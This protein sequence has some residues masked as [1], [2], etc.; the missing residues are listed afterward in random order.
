[1]KYDLIVQEAIE[2]LQLK[3]Q[4]KE[5]KI[6]EMEEEIREIEERIE[7]IKLQP[8]RALILKDIMN[9]LKENPN[10]SE[11]GNRTLWTALNYLNRGY[12]MEANDKVKTLYEIS[13]MTEEELKH[14]RGIGDKM[15]EQIKIL[16]QA[17]GLSLKSK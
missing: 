3:K 13:N 15:V 2:K 4:E 1:M 14:R 8:E 16:L 17:Y 6:R 11:S 5:Q 10:Y 12:G 7:L 9:Q